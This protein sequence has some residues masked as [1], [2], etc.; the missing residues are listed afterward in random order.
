MATVINQGD[1]PFAKRAAHLEKWQKTLRSSLLN[2]AAG[3]DQIAA[4]K[5]KLSDL[6]TGRSYTGEAKTKPGCIDCA[7]H[8]PY[9]RGYI[10]EIPSSSALSKMRKADLIDLSVTLG[11]SL[12]SD[13]K[14]S[15][16]ID[17]IEQRRK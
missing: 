10:S 4:I 2:P 14:K 5:K 1:I 11:L 7:T 8:E 12:T 16:I 3:S 9:A 13:L 17:A 6:Q 15:D